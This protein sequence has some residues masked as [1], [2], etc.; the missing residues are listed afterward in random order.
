LPRKTATVMKL[1]FALLITLPALYAQGQ[2]QQAPQ[3]IGHADWEYIFSQMPEYKQIETELKSFE[4]QLQNQLKTK[5]QEIETKYK[6]YTSLPANTLD[7]IKKD[8]ESELAYL[9]ENLQKFQQDAQASMQK[10]QNDLVSPV[11]TKVGKAIESVAR[12]NGFSY[13]IN[14][15][16][17]NGGDVLL[18]TDE[19]Y[20]I[21]NLV[22]KKLGIDPPKEPT[23]PATTTPA[24]KN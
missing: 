7:A 2:T 6:A 3:K 17:I 24:K 12:E 20:N 16:M 13:I 14:P 18:F 15:H 9:Q 22:L 11:F 5:G 1:L 23:T 8:K 21:S 10:K 4:T 19:Q